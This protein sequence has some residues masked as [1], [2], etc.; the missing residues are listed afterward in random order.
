[1]FAPD[2][3]GLRILESHRDRTCA[4]L[5][6]DFRL[7]TLSIWC[8]HRRLGQVVLP[9][10]PPPTSA[11]HAVTG[12]TRPGVNRASTAAEVDGVGKP[13]RGGN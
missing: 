12:V 11:R 5:A 13:E 4:A 9:T 8:Y 10:P 7:H 3:V 2:R 6:L 1:M